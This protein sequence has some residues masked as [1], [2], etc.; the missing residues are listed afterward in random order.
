MPKFELLRRDDSTLNVGQSVKFIE[1]DEYHHI[2]EYHS[3]IEIGRSLVIDPKMD[4]YKWMTS[5][6]VEIFENKKDKIVFRTENSSY[7]L[8]IYE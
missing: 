1:W 4:G 8:Y 2:K 7:T 3:E 6:V 5:P